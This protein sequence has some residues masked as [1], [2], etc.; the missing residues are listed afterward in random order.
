MKGGLS[1]IALALGLLTETLLICVGSD[2][3]P[4]GCRARPL[5]GTAFGCPSDTSA[6]SRFSASV[7][8]AAECRAL[9]HPP[10]VKDG[11]AYTHRQKLYAR[12]DAP[13]HRQFAARC[14]ASNDYTAHDSGSKDGAYTYRH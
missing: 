4:N 6:R 7:G 5:F 3:Q 10:A 1:C 13:P 12:L 8:R 14:S 11:R 2:D 9:R